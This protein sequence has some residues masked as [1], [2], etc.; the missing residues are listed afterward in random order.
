M[1]IVIKKCKAVNCAIIKMMRFIMNI[2]R[3]YQIRQNFPSKKLFFKNCNYDHSLFG[4]IFT[5][6]WMLRKFT[7]PRPCQIKLIKI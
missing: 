7:N 6:E 3:I 4:N 2:F 1:F 5:C